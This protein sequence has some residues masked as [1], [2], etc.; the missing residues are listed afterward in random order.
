[1]RAV[2]AHLGFRLVDPN[3]PP[4]AIDAVTRAGGTILSHGEF[5]PGEPYAFVTD[6]DGDQLEIWFE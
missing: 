1:M 6:P 2:N 3:D 5:C 4:A